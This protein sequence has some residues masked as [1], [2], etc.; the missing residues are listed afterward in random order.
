MISRFAAAL[1]LLAAG[2][3]AYR[4]EIERWREQAERSLRADDGWLT[5]AGLFWLKE[6]DNRLGSGKGN[7]I[8][9]PAGSAPARA[10][11]IRFQSG[12]AELQIAPGVRAALNGKPVV[13]AVMRPD[14]D[15]KPDVLT[16]G[17]LSLFVIQRGDRFGIRLKD[18]N[19]RFR[20]NFTGR[21]WFP[22]KED[23]RVTARFEPHARPRQISIPNV[24]GQIEKMASPG[25]VVFRWKGQEVSLEPVASGERLWFIFRDRTSGKETY[26]AGRFLYSEAPRDGKVVLDFNQAYNPPC[27][28]T[29]YATCPLPPR[30]NWLPVRIEAGE[31]TY[32]AE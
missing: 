20:R 9:L 4:A 11:V 27:A 1:M 17:D 14:S 24:L 5:V 2:D 21:K 13:S 18:K 31:L 32:H 30:Q 8:E 28:F 29:P 15:G 7:E 6:G 12:K 26:P 22:V 25:R 16:L 10:G 19:S 23:Y 3:A